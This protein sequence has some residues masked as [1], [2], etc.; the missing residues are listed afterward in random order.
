MNELIQQKVLDRRVSYAKRG[1]LNA[2][3]AGAFWGLN[4]ILL[5]F[6]FNFNPYLTAASIFVASIVQAGI[7]DGCAS[8]WLF[9]YNIKNGKLKEYIRVLKTRPGKIICLGGIC[10]GPIAMTGYVLGINMCGAAYAMPISALCPIVGAFLAAIF[11]KEKINLRVW[12]GVVLAVGGAIAV[13]YVPP[14]G[15]SS[16][17]FYLGIALSCL[18]TLGWGFEGALGAYGL[19][20]VDPNL[21]TGIK[22]LSSFVVYFVFVIPICGGIGF[23]L[24]SF[25]SLGAIA[26]IAIAALTGGGCY[27]L[28]YKALNMTGVSRTMALNDT[29][30]IWGLIFTWICAKFG[31]MEFSFTPNLVI[32]AIVLLIGVII[33]I[34]NPKD[35]V[36]I[37]DN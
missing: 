31:W 10:G 11:L 32:G 35:L 37:R 24:E 19:D 36:R 9:L 18:A 4:G 13:S 34:A 27:I 12:I 22:Y 33:V 29:Y 8:L 2:V 21:A 23:T 25:A 16:S 1:M 28:W 15:V 7:H 30:V 26:F 17:T 6:V 5:G 3:I 20:L 14:E